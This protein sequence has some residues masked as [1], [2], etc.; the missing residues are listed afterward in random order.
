MCGST[1]HRFVDHMG[2]I[3]QRRRC[4]FTRDRCTQ[5]DCGFS[6]TGGEELR[7]KEDMQFQYS[8]Y[9]HCVLITPSKLYGRQDSHSYNQGCYSPAHQHRDCPH[10]PFNIKKGKWVAHK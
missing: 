5:Y 1:K 10:N 7:A 4:K 3:K 6:H 8:R 2:N 9:T